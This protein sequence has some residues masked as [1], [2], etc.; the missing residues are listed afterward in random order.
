MQT[1]NVLVVGPA[2]PKGKDFGADFVGTLT[3]ARTYLEK[4]Q[5]AVLVFGHSRNG[6][7]DKFC[8]YALKN[9]PSSLWIVAA[10]G[11]PP[12]TL[13]HWNNVGQLHGLIDDFNDPD[14]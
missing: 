8:E 7:F 5:P 4:H 1:S 12:S 13:L 3:E 10:E 6:E 2:R 9:S 11:L 14:L